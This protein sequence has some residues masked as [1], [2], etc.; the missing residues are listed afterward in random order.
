MFLWGKQFIKIKIFLDY[1]RLDVD[2]PEDKLRLQL[3]IHEGD[4]KKLLEE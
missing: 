3:Q 4:D 2:I 1:L